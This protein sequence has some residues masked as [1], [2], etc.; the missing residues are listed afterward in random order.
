MIETRDV[1]PKEKDKEPGVL[2]EGKKLEELFLAA[3]FE[4]AALKVS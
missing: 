2:F 4:T 3:H 1:S